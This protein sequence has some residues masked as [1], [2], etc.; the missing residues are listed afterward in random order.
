MLPGGVAGPLTL[1]RGATIGSV[2]APPAAD[3]PGP[4]SGVFR[5]ARDE[6]AV[7]ELTLVQSG[8][9]VS[10]VGS[11]LG[12]RVGVTGAVTE[13][14]T[15][16]YERLRGVLTYLD[17]TQIPFVADLAADGA[18]IRLEGLGAPLDLQRTERSE[19]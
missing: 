5:G 1:E 7:A 2:G 16:G 14:A 19:P 11:V 18:S 17:E 8:T 6:I 15:S 12:S 10:G 3:P 9:L 13:D 4:Y